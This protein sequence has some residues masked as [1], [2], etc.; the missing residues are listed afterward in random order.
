MTDG[1]WIAE[2]FTQ[3]YGPLLEERAG[4]IPAQRR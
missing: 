4:V 1:L 2:G 3:Y